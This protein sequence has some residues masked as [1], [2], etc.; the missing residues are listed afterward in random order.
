MNNSLYRYRKP[1]TPKVEIAASVEAKPC[2][3][4]REQK[5]LREFHKSKQR[6]DGRIS[7][8]KSCWSYNDRNNPVR[9][10]TIIKCRTT[11]NLN[12]PEK[13]TAASGKRRADEIKATPGWFNKKEVE[14]IYRLSASCRDEYGDKYPT[15]HR[16]PLNGRKLE[17]ADCTQVCG[18]HVGQNLEPFPKRPNSQKSNKLLPQY[19]VAPEAIPDGHYKVWVG[20]VYGEGFSIA[21]FYN[22]ELIRITTT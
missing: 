17:Y 5:L 6:K 14:G 16:V 7:I 13:I 15:D 22:K 21:E 10:T 8:C 18:L 11:W 9:I 12:N 2:T 1:L 4:C 20:D 3:T 19:G